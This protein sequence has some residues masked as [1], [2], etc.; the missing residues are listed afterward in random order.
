MATISKAIVDTDLRTQ[1]FDMMNMDQ[2]EGL[3]TVNE[4]TFGTILTD[5]N[6]VER[7][8]RV[9]AI[10]AEIRDDMTAREY[11]Q[12]EQEAYEKKQAEK[13]RK[14]EEKAE[15]AKRDK[16]KREAAK[17]KKEANALPVCDLSQIPVGGKFY[18][19][20]QIGVKIREG[21]D[22]FDVVKFDGKEESELR[23]AANV[24]PM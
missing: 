9:K 2:I 4:Q 13:K 20:Q 17:V 5:K 22:G 24:I 14:A 8:V 10:I 3:E 21:E 7:Y 12:S 16:E 1:L 6:G 18:Y 15:K 23:R 19:N 11:M